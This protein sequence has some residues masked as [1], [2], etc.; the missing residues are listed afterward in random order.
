VKAIGFTITAAAVTFAVV[1]GTLAVVNDGDP[2]PSA[3]VPAFAPASATDKQTR[4]LEAAVRAHP[5]AGGLAAVA[6]A[7]LERARRV[8]GADLY[9][10]AARALEAALERDPRN[11]DALT[12]MA[13]LSL[14]R[15][16][17]AGGLRWARSARAAQPR[18]TRAYPALVDAH[19]E[20]GQY[21]AAE[22]ALERFVEQRPGVASYARISYLRE[23]HGDL[24]GAAAAM[25][26]AVVAAAD[27]A[28]GPSL[29]NLLGGIELQRG[30]TSAAERAFRAVLGQ[31]PGDTAA[32]VG[33]ARVALAR[34][35]LQGG[36]RRL[37]ATVGPGSAWFEHL[38]LA[39][40]ELAAGHGGA[41]RR[42]LAS[43]RRAFA[44]LRAGGENTDTEAAL[45]E[46]TLGDPRV[47]VRLARRGHAVAPSVRA[48]DALGWALTRAGR[49]REG[50]PWA[51]RALRLGSR[52]P[53][54]LF[55]A[56]LAA[57]AAG[58]PAAARAYL[59]RALALNP[60]FSPLHASAARRA[61]ASLERRRPIR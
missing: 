8:G 61:L 14:A 13:N 57:R 39:E 28:D 38:A 19:V 23:L 60:R 32:Q 2:R 42:E 53:L 21:A 49:P 58:E 12:G 25:R 52:D 45:V 47:A 9:P 22:R 16:D 10:A 17:F 43:A 55:H 46:A 31:A 37:R 4:T 15:H 56:G 30:R 20:L 6:L 59:S 48:A 5:S 51:R 50:L 26:L 36:L 40:A 29:R 27:N 44:Q 7:Y 35:D 34:G 41:G 3:R 33:L 18:L 1:L 54:F 11:V 24:E